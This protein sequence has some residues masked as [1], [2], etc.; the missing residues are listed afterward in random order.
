MIE[1]MGIKRKVEIITTDFSTMIY[2]VLNSKR[3]AVLPKYFA[4]KHCSDKD[5][6]ILPLPFDAPK[7]NESIMWHPTLDSDPVHRWLREKIISHSA[8]YRK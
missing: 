1:S 3:L 6:K 4:L 7:L 8:I 2:T 5:F